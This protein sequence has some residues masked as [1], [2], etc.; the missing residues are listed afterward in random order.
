M[1]TFLLPEG[2]MEEAWKNAVFVLLNVQRDYVYS[3]D[4]MRW[5][6]GGRILTQQNRSTRRKNVSKREIVG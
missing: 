3:A 5:S 6:P 1:N 4:G 2:Q